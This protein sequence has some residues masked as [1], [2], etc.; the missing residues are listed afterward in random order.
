MSNAIHA[1]IHK[2]DTTGQEEKKVAKSNAIHAS[3]HP[4]DLTGQDEEEEEVEKAKK[5]EVK[6]SWIE[7]ILKAKKI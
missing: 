2:N 6:L 5:A 3:I 7:K 4:D 1:S